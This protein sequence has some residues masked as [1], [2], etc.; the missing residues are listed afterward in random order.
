MKM[1]T[2]DLMQIYEEGKRGIMDGEIPYMGA[3][4]EIAMAAEEIA[5]VTEIPY[6]GVHEKIAM[7]VEEALGKV[8]IEPELMR[9]SSEAVRLLPPPKSSSQIVQE[10]QL[11][12]LR[13]INRNTAGL[14]E[15]VELIS[16][17]NENQDAI[18]EV[19]FELI[20]LAKE[21]DVA[22]VESKYKKIQRTIKTMYGT[23]VT[24]NKLFKIA[25]VVRDAVE[26]ALSSCPY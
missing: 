26:T 6:M 2:N 18:L 16:K 11:E 14:A 22:V 12:E 15:I 4:E 25:E 7:E 13:S 5:M 9:L 21:K 20:A 23:T 24:G 1:T 3:Y 8:Q 17:S 10:Q 19:L